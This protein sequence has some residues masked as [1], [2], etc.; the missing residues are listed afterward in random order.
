MGVLMYHIGVVC[1]VWI[2]DCVIDIWDCFREKGP[3]VQDFNFW[4]GIFEV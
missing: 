4:G 2:G 1:S 3:N